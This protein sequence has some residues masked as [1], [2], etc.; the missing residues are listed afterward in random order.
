MLNIVDLN[1]EINRGNA[2]GLTFHFDGEDAPENGTE[3]IFYVEEYDHIGN[4]LIEKRATVNN[5]TVTIDFDPNDT[6]NIKPGLY[7]WNACIQYMAGT[8]PWTVLRDWPR[9]SVLPG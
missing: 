1:I 3:V 5:N 2:A 4:P 8:K 6:K 9:F 7:C